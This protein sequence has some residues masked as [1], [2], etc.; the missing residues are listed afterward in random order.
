VDSHEDILRDIVDRFGVLQ[1]VAIARDVLARPEEYEL[2]FAGG[3]LLVGV[4]ADDDTIR[5]GRGRSELPDRI[6]VSGWDP[7][8]RALGASAIWAWQLRNQ[9]GYSDALQVEFA[10]DEAFTTVQLV[11]QASAIQTLAVEEAESLT[12]PWNQV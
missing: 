3:V 8:Q 2:T 6:D 4:H 12:M 5:L 10:L 1:S 9:Q 7:W 11:C